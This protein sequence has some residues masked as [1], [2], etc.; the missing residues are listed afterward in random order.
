[1]RMA[2]PVF[3]VLVVDPFVWGADWAW[4]VPLIVLTVVIHVSVLGI[5]SG[6]VVHFTSRPAVGRHPRTAFVAGVG[7]TTLLAT[8]LHGFEAGIW[9]LAY[10]FLGTQPNFGSSMLYSLNAITSYGHSGLVL[11]EH[12]RLLG[13]LESINGWLL[14]GLTTAFQFAVIGKMWPSATG[15]DNS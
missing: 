14:F 11:E 3:S 13:S 5:L 4:A 6:R 1:M 7:T 15:N 12:W 8:C 2:H 10:W 9:A